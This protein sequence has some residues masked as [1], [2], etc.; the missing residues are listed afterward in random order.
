MS[1]TPPPHVRVG[2]TGSP[3]PTDRR[4]P[5]RLARGVT[6]YLLAWTK[7]SVVPAP[8]HTVPRGASAWSRGC[9]SLYTDDADKGG[10]SPLPR[11]SVEDVELPRPSARAP[12]VHR[13][14]GLPGRP[15]SLHGLPGNVDRRH[16][17]PDTKTEG[18]EGSTSSGRRHPM[19]SAAMFPAN[20][21]T[22][23]A[24]LLQ[25]KII[26]KLRRRRGRVGWWPQKNFMPP[27]RVA[28]P[29]A[30]TVEDIKR[31]HPGDHRV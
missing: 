25:N 15:L 11:R 8:P 19:L 26:T 27:G 31:T 7:P 4:A 28:I 10:R 12:A 29:A 30:M 5:P 18:C 20:V 9:R 14:R 23:L 13:L 21:L 1:A 24:N 2:Y 16:L 6:K 17:A 22:S 3:H